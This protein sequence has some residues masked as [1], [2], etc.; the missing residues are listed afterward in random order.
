MNMLAQLQKV[1]CTIN[2]AFYRRNCLAEIDYKFKTPTI[3]ILLHFQLRYMCMH[4]A[5][6]NKRT[7]YSDLISIASDEFF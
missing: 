2:E 4:Y 3:N 7:R 5:Y 6:A 1:L